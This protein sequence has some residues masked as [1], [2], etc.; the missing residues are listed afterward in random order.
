MVYYNIAVHINPLKG[1]DCNV[2]GYD[3]GYYSEK[4]IE[5]FEDDYTK[6]AK[7]I[8]DVSREDLKD[9]DW[10][11]HLAGLSNYPLGE[12][13]PSLPEEFN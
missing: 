4:I 10:I 13:S 1:K 5:L 6:I 11:I 3:S 7:D 8:R 12:F 2:V 9:I